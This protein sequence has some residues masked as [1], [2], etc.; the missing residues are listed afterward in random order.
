MGGAVRSFGRGLR[1]IVTGPDDVDIP[2]VRPPE[3]APEQEAIDV[4]PDALANIN[5]LEQRQAATGGRRGTILTGTQTDPESIGTLITGPA[6]QDEAT[7]LIDDEEERQERR[8]QREEERELALSFNNR[9]NFGG[10][11]FGGR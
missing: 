2:D 3:D 7:E 6:L 11:R 10:R 5:V 4:D 8:R 9:G 1:S